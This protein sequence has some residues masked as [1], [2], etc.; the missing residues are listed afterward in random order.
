MLGFLSYEI[1]VDFFQLPVKF[2]NFK[3]TIETFLAVATDQGLTITIRHI[4]ITLTNITRYFTGA[5]LK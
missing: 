3:I 1:N 2:K 5:K 4:T